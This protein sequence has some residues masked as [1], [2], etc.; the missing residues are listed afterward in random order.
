[1]T[2]I[3]PCYIGTHSDR[4]FCYNISIPNCFGQFIRFYMLNR[5]PRQYIVAP[6]TIKVFIKRG[7][8]GS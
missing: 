3:Q 2:E 8:L 5:R 7:R 6:N 1:M 4:L